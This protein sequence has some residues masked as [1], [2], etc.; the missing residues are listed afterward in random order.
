MS[1]ESIKLLSELEENY[2]NGM[3]DVFEFLASIPDEYIPNKEDLIEIIRERRNEN[4]Y[5]SKEV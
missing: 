2:K 1:A 3:L 5:N 4:K